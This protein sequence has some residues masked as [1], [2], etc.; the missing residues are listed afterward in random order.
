MLLLAASTV[1]T[2]CVFAQ[3]IDSLQTDPL[4]SVADSL[5]STIGS[6]LP[7]LYLDAGNPVDVGRPTHRAELHL[8]ALLGN[9]PGVFSYYFGT[10]GWPD[11]ISLDGGDPN[12][13]SV[14]LD[15]MP[16][17]DLI[18]GGP[19]YDLLPY[20]LIER[21]GITRSAAGSVAQ[22]HA[23]SDRFNQAEPRTDLRYRS[24][25]DGLTYIDAIH[26]QNRRVRLGASDYRLMLLAGYS[27]S[28]HTGEY[29]GS[30]L[31][32]SKQI[33][34]RIRLERPA[35]SLEIFELYNRRSIGA[36]AGVLPISG[37]PYES[38]Y[39]RLGASVD[40]PTA[41]RG[42]IRNDLRIRYRRLIVGLPLTVT[43]FWNTERLSF[44]NPT[45]SLA[46]RIHRFGGSIDQRLGVRGH[47]VSVWASAW[48]DRYAESQS[49]MGTSNP[50]RSY[51]ELKLSD[52]TRVFG[53]SLSMN[54]GV[55]S[56][57]GIVFPSM[58]VNYEYGPGHITVSYTGI[59]SSWID[60]RGFGAY[61][62]TTQEQ[63]RMRQARGAFDIGTSINDFSARLTVFATS[64]QNRVVW[65][66][67]ED[68]R[69]V[70]A[71]LFSDNFVRTGAFLDLMFRSP[72]RSGFYALLR[73][74]YVKASSADNDPIINAEI[75]A[76]P[77]FWLHG[78][79][80]IQRRMFKD[81]LNLNVSVRGTWSGS[82]IGRRL[83]TRSGLLMLPVDPAHTVAESGRVDLVAEA[84]IKSAI[85]FLSFENILYGKSTRKGILIIPDYPIPAQ[86][87][88]FG[89]FWSI[90]N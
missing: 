63:P 82:M 73:P 19:R 57:D 84:E 24:S 65:T 36:Q 28:S 9:E 86:R 87:F 22:L 6:T 10:L 3:H 83:D 46:A 43:G 42:T 14:V 55:H 66:I 8:P 40:D 54:V 7:P 34:A 45:D 56:D 50:T 26:S 71:R 38:I 67:D 12:R 27:G 30:A 2:P 11:V 23:L 75:E 72:Y 48:I 61:S 76:L 74:T 31:K 69:A 51:A 62:T 35:W 39:Q 5:R 13:V 70:S 20:T 21:I 37:Q 77:A 58:G 90:L 4:D 33:T 32:S 44:T 29:P 15:G 49:D 85:L 53:S 88:R 81:D 59:R 41:Q 18:T 78:R 80:G 64:I 1:C 25:S 79:A 68:S 89:I 52:S 17:E 16:F 60:S 47:R